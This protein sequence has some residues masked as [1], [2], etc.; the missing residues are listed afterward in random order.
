MSSIRLGNVVE[1]SVKTGLEKEAE[2]Q[3]IGQVSPRTSK[4]IK[5][6]VYENIEKNISGES[7][8]PRGETRNKSDSVHMEGAREGIKYAVTELPKQSDYDHDTGEGVKYAVTDLPKQSDY[9]H[10]DADN[11]KGRRA[12]AGDE[13]AAKSSIE[14]RSSIEKSVLN[15]PSFENTTTVETS[16]DID[17]DFDDEVELP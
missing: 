10:D 5:S 2:G 16:F 14:K 3:D 13:T 4:K 8:S 6:S 1:K 7:R 11:D 15:L 17:E 9:D 12:S